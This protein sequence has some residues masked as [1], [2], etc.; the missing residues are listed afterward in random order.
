[1][2]VKIPMIKDTPKFATPSEFEVVFPIKQV[3]Y[4]VTDFK[5]E[6]PMVV[7]GLQFDS[8][9]VMYRCS[10]GDKTNCYYDFE[11]IVKPDLQP[12]GFAYAHNGT[13]APILEQPHAGD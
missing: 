7:I 1:M 6:M 2:I 4:H 8:T 13:A 10:S 3:V 12:V 11:L 9:S 5:W